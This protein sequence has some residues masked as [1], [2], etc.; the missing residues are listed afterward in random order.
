MGVTSCGLRRL[1]WVKMNA[2]DQLAAYRRT[3]SDKAFAELVRRYANLVYSVAKRRVNDG[4]LA[5]DV[6]QTVFSRLAKAPPTLRSEGELAAWLHRTATHAAID[7]WRSEIRRR[8]REQ[9]AALIQSIPDNDTRLWEELSPHLDEALDTLNEGDRQVLLLRFF[10]RKPMCEVGRALGVSEDAA[11]MRVSRAIDRLRQRLS[12]RGVTCG[13]ALLAPALTA[14]AAEAAPAQLLARLAAI[15]LITPT[16]GVWTELVSRLTAPKVAVGAATVG[17]VLTILIAMV[18]ARPVEDHAP[19][20]QVSNSI[21]QAPEGVPGERVFR[22][23]A[24]RRPGAVERDANT[25]FILRL[26]DRETGAAIAGAQVRGAYFYAGGVGERHDWM[27]DA[28]GN[29]HV[30]YQNDRERSAGLN[31]F[32]HLPG[33]VPKAIG[34]GLSP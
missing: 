5:E 12:V 4:P 8:A 7:A 24:V 34:F 19:S 25:K 2:A 30:Q 3:G 23:T 18:S 28:D 22:R 14:R 16:G 29:V 21:E 31:V 1:S 13:V 27:S 11:K 33:Y 26:V 20:L 9:E 32:V 17:L 10:E 6:T 15:E